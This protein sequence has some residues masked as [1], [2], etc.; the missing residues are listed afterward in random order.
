MI[1][2]MTGYG[3][4]IH[5]GDKLTIRV[6]L[7]SLNG[8]YFDLNLRLS[9]SLRSHESEIRTLLN[10]KLMRGKTDALI[11]IEY[12]GENG[13]AINRELAKRYYAELKSLAKEMEVDKKNLFQIVM[14]IPEV[15]SA[16]RTE[17]GEEEWTMV[18]ETIHRAAEDLIQFRIKEGR[19]LEGSFHQN[20]RV[21]LDCLGQVE[22]FE[23]DRIESVRGRLHSQLTEN[24][25]AE[26]YDR[27]RFEQELI[28]YLER[29]D[30]SEEK[31]RL[32]S[33]CDFFMQSLDEK[34]SN[35]RRLNFIS[36]EMGREINTLG[37]KANHAEIQKLVVQMKDELEK[38][39]EQLLNV[40]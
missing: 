17:S 9:S 15:L 24:L 31:T 16:E 20:I 33:H 13:S 39:K 37:S 18:R 14:Q 2:S 6:E 25:S 40:L 32:K 34:E 4:A 22:S 35:G 7:R 29:M 1:L 8:R 5:I 27:N 23:K 30:F 36:Q 28:F 12:S 26:N 11:I 21:I 19:A 3:K 38:I 10:E